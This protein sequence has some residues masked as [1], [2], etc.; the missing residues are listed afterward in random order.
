MI[1]L[2]LQRATRKRPSKRLRENIVIVFDK[3]ERSRLEVVDR[4]ETGTL[5]KPASENRE[6]DLD[7]VEP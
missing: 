6:P 7:L 5:E 2:G 1:S 4:N 3:L